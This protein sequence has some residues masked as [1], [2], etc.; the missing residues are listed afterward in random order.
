MT[1]YDL[2]FMF[3]LHW[4]IFGPHTCRRDFRDKKSLQIFN[5]ACGYSRAEHWKLK[6]RDWYWEDD[7]NLRLVQRFRGN[8]L[9]GKNLQREKNLTNDD[10]WGHATKKCQLQSH[11]HG[12]LVLT[13]VIEST[14]HYLGTS[15]LRSSSR[16]SKRVVFWQHIL[17]MKNHRFQFPISVHC[18]ENLHI[19]QASILGGRI[20]FSHGD[21]T[22]HFFCGSYNSK[23]MTTR[24]RTYKVGDTN[25]RRAK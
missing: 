16:T 9:V 22:K 21:S 7:L 8:A 6:E 1:L 5:L 4:S 10:G 3:D 23:L 14:T 15:P 13:L 12:T 2:S 18:M 11:N 17:R 20:T 25:S 24:K 19:N